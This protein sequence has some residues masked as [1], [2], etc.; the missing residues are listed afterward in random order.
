MKPLIAVTNVFPDSALRRLYDRCDLQYNHSGQSLSADQLAQAA[1]ECEAMITYLSDKVDAR[2]LKGAEGLKII[3]NY[4]A[5]F[6]NI[7]VAI[8]SGKKIWVTNTPGVLHETTADFTWALLL[9][10][11]RQ[12]VP[13]DR[14]TREGRFDGWQ[15]KLFLGH[16]VYR[17]TLGIVG[18]GEIGKAVARRASGFNMRVLYHQRKQ[19]PM[20]E[21]QR[22]NAEYRRASCLL[23][24]RT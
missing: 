11:A 7:D 14:Y 10:I 5:G 20:E 22:L 9:G 3:A 8:A 15:A 1:G 13:A 4:G 18:C 24:S 6:N 23:I 16:D 17:K 12:I 19:L 2:I 21:E